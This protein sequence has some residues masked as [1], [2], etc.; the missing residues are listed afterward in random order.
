MKYSI[1]S[2]RAFTPLLRCSEKLLSSSIQNPIGDTMD[3]LE[4]LLSFF[5]LIIIGLILFAPFIIALTVFLITND[6]A[7]I[8]LGVIAQAFWFAFLYELMK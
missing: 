1:I 6:I 3:V 5:A 4:F 8:V 7:W 2:A